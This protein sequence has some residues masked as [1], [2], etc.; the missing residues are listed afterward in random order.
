M[1]GQQ[2]VSSNLLA[3]DPSKFL[4]IYRQLLLFFFSPN[5]FNQTRKAWTSFSLQN[6]TK[7]F[8]QNIYTSIHAGSFVQKSS[9]K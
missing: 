4:N 3:Q 1:T 6:K 8:F 7:K 2:H 9:I 5:N